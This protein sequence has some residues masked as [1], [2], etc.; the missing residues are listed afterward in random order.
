[1]NLNRNLKRSY[2]KSHLDDKKFDYIRTLRKLRKKGPDEDS[3]SSHYQSDSSYN[4]KEEII[5]AERRQRKK[6]GSDDSE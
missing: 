4:I 3:V 6:K 1:V 5:K 2:D